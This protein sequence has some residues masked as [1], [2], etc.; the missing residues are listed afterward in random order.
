[1]DCYRTYESI[2]LGAIPIVDDVSPKMT[3]DI[4]DQAPTYILDKDWRSHPPTEQDLLAF[5]ADSTKGRKVALAQYWLDQ[6]DEYRF[7]AKGKS[8]SYS[9]M[10]Y[11]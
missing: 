8:R 4:F 5:K 1:M 11:L 10:T 2:L 9:T 3:R 7:E 6:I